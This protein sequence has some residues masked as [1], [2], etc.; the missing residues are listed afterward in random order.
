MI[1]EFF[2]I[3]HAFIRALETYVSSTLQK[4]NGCKIIEKGPKTL[5]QIVGTLLIQMGVS[6]LP[7]VI[8]H[9]FSYK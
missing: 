4:F 8:L 5:D 1:E 7:R 6:P 9:G 2:V 3:F